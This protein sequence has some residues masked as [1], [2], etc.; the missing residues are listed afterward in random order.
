MRERNRKTGI[1]SEQ[2]ES[3]LTRWVGRGNIPTRLDFLAHS[4]KKKEE[5]VG[6]TLTL[7]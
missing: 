5:E 6:R 1:S 2:A 4:I 7:A 3:L